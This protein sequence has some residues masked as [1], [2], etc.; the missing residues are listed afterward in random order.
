MIETVDYLI[1]GGGRAAASAVEEL[2]D[3]GVK[4]HITIVGAE[5]H[6]PYDRPPLSKG[7][8]QGLDDRESLDIEGQDFYRQN[9]VDLILGHRATRLNGAERTVE[10]DDGRILG[11]RKL[12]LV[13]GARL[14]QLD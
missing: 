13:P 6:L 9:R 2:V 7:F 11:F 8:L 12:L 14:R 3:Q 10:I 1:V 4:G 5:P